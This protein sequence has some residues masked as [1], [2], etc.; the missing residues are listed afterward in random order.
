VF[1]RT[2][3]SLPG[4]FEQ[5]FYKWKLLQLG[6]PLWHVINLR[7]AIN[8]VMLSCIQMP[9]VWER[10]HVTSGR[11]LY[12]NIVRTDFGTNISE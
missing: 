4:N 12:Q 9:G 10:T 6:K 11:S 5:I 2:K 1:K 8:S 7:N 3:L